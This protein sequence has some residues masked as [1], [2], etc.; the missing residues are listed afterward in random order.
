M[1]DVLQQLLSAVDEQLRSPQTT[2]VKATFDRL[3]GGGM[4]EADAREEIAD[5]LGQEL[6]EM[7]EQ[8]RSFQEASYRALLDA[9]PW[10]EKPL[11]GID[12]E[13]L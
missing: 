13:N 8:G 9:L 5:C 11:S 6:D 4:S 12:L 3:I 10:Q 7:L 1:S 2:Y